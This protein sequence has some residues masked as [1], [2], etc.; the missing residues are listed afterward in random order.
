MGN[1]C[2]F[3]SISY[4]MGKGSKTYWMGKAWEFDFHIFSKYGCF[5]P[6]DSHPVVCFII[7]E[8]HG[9]FH[10]FPIT[11]EKAAKCIEWEKGICSW[12][13]P[14][15]PIPWGEP[16][17]L[18]LKLFHTMG[19]FSFRFSSYGIL[20]HMGNARVSPFTS[21]SIGQ[22]SEIHW[23]GTA[24]KIGIHTFPKVW[25]LFFRQIPTLWYTLPHEKSMDF[26]ISFWKHGKIQQNPPCDLSGCFSTVLFFLLVP[27]SGDSLKEQTEKTD[28]VNSVF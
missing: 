21:H 14:I 2:V 27:N 3:S 12:K 24:W 16:G 17:K 26:P 11:W 28:K 23:I 18:V 5:F 22:C 8:T 6:L 20:H 19:A 9:F 4:S 25:V 1:A 15:K 13:N 7:R 10:Q